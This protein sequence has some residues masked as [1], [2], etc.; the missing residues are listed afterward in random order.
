MLTVRNGTLRLQIC[1]R[2]L[3]EA[4]QNQVSPPLTRSS[5]DESRRTQTLTDGGSVLSDAPALPPPQRH[6]PQSPS[7]SC[8]GPA[9]RPCAET[10][11]F[12][13]YL[14]PCF[15]NYQDSSADLLI[16]CYNG[17]NLKKQNM[18]DAG[19]TWWNVV[20]RKW[21]TVAVV[22]SDKA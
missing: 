21:K 11:S 9:Q 15:L 8:R 1:G 3:T 14:S 20:G 19:E 18:A 22:H 13:G 2:S 12:L 4:V 10:C 17:H 16:Y 7:P 5:L 6:T